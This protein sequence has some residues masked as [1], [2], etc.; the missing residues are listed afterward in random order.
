MNDDLR[1][2]APTQEAIAVGL[3]ADGMRQARS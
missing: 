2:H 1:H 3:R